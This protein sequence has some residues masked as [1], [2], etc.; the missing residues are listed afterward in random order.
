MKTPYKIQWVYD[1][2]LS[3]EDCFARLKDLPPTNPYICS[4][5]FCTVVSN[6]KMEF[7]FTQAAGA[8]RFYRTTYIAEF[9]P[10][11]TG[12]TV[13]VMRFINELG[14]WLPPVITYEQIDD[15]FANCIQAYRRK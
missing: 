12:R 14:I 3:I 11:E 2:K 1:T 8:G 5:V 4:K 13:I 7:V 10:I 6:T 9:Y 15:F